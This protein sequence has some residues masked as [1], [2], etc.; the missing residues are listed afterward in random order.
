MNKEQIYNLLDSKNISY[1]VI[2]HKKVFT[3]EE[4]EK[5]NLPYKEY[6]A[7]N[8]FVR[9]DK[10]KHYYLITIKGNKKLDLKSFKEK[11]NTKRL[12]FASSDELLNILGLTPGSVTPFGLLNDKER[13]V[14]FYIDENLNDK[15]GVHPNDNSATVFLKVSDLTNLLMDNNIT[16]NTFNVK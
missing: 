1:E 15:I 5:I 10:K 2:N 7:K 4:L 6:D 16:V 9:D 11:Y 12:S 3:M 8:L 13:K 14:V